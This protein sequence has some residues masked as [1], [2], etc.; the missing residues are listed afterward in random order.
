MD[1]GAVAGAS[2]RRFLFRAMPG[3]VG[4]IGRRLFFDALVA[5]G[6]T[7]H[8]EPPPRRVTILRPLAPSPTRP[9]LHA[10]AGGRFRGGMIP[11]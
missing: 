6:L 10:T 8:E 7:D 9:R 4:V 5:E 2:R 3:E 11:P 1:A